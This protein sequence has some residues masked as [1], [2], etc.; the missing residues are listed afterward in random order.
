VSRRSSGLLVYRRRANGPLEVFLVHPGGPF[1][2]DKD[3]G[4]WSV[5]KGEIEAG[6]DPLT[7]ARREFAEEVGSAVPAGE[8]LG[9][10]EIRQSNGKRVIAWAVRGDVDAA[11]LSSNTFELEWPPRSGKTRS[12][13][14]IDRGQWFAADVARRKLVRGQDA[15]V[16]RLLEALTSESA[17]T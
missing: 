5:P 1:W 16:D 8:L 17:E 2:T 11:S 9:L 10:G 12:F 4:A 6:E 15:F 7:V 14:E 13:P 3:E